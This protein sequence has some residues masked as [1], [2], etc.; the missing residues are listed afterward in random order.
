MCMF[1]LPTLFD[2]YTLL[3]IHNNM[4]RHNL[5]FA[6]V[7]SCFFCPLL[8]LK[9]FIFNCLSPRRKANRATK[10]RLNNAKYKENQPEES[11]YTKPLCEGFW[12]II[13]SS[14]KCSGHQFFSTCSDQGSSGLAVWFSLI[15][16][17]Q[18]ILLHIWCL[19]KDIFVF[20]TDGRCM[21][22]AIHM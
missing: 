14:M 6:L 1:Q 22:F 11:I 13:F 16:S 8:P 18:P 17:C 21:S 3:L 7:Q 15:T 2:N 19:I 12:A 4:M 20:I 9:M 10:Q 5:P